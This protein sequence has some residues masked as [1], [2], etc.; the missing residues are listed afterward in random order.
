MLQGFRVLTY[1]IDEMLQG[2]RG[3][4]G[5]RVYRPSKPRKYGRKIY[6]LIDAKM[7]YTTSMEGRHFKFGIS[8]IIMQPIFGT[9]RNVT[10]DN[11]FT[12]MEVANKLLKVHQLT[13]IGTLRKNK[14]HIPPPLISIMKK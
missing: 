9:K 3:K 1:N 7:Y 2:F 8:S 5:F 12:S 4:C 10:M 11:F 13:I 6:A 14:K